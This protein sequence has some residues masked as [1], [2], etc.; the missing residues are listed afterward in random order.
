MFSFICF[1]CCII[2]VFLDHKFLQE[3]FVS[4]VLFCALDDMKLIADIYNGNIPVMPWAKF[5][6]WLAIFSQLTSSQ[7]ASG[8]LSTY[9]N[10]H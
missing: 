3:G 4:P 10:E 2:L 8:E 6:F 7:L 1:N 9:H 5:L